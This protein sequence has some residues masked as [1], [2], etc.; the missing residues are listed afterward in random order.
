MPVKLKVKSEGQQPDAVTSHSNSNICEKF[1]AIESLESAAK[2]KQ[3]T[4]HAGAPRKSC[5][6]KNP[7]QNLT[8]PI[9]LSSG[10]KS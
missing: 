4:L 10:A 2:K 8:T 3:Q 6:K 7:K 9:R 1:T 5:W